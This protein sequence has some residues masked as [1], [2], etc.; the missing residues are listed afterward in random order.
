MGRLS[1]GLQ[2][3]HTELREVDRSVQYTNKFYTYNL[4]S[5]LVISYHPYAV[6][7]RLKDYRLFTSGHVMIFVAT[8]YI[9]PV[10]LTPNFSG[11]FEIKIKN[12]PESLSISIW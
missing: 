9:W 2:S 4:W 12:N 1:I 7:H 10:S 6:E 8:P 3:Q 5:P 11:P